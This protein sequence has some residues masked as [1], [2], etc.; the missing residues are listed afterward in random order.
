MI[1]EKGYIYII[2]TRASKNINENVYK[3][4]KTKNYIS[5]INGYMK[6]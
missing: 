2:Y 5:R 3:I 6:G 4:G 1:N